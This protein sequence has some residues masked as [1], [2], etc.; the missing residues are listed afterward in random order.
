[1]PSDITTQVTLRSVFTDRIRAKHYARAT[2]KTYWN[3]TVDFVRFNGGRPPRELGAA[4]VEAFLSHLAVERNVSPSTQNQALAALLFLYREVLQLD[5]PWL[6]GITRAKP[7]HFLPTVLSVHETQQLLS[8]ITGTS[9]LI[10]RLLY[11]TGMRVMECLRLRVGDVDMQRNVVTVRQGKGGKDRT[12]CLPET[13]KHALRMQ[14]DLRRHL[15]KLDIE[16]GMVDVELPDA[17]IRKYPRARFEWPWQWIFCTRGYLRIPDGSGVRRHHIE[18]RPI[19]RA[20]RDASRLARINKRVTPHT[21]RHCFAT[22]LLEGGAD[23]RTVQ[24][25]LGHSD[26]STT[27]IYTHVMHRVGLGTISPLDRILTA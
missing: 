1:M 8:H 12:T 24:E 14:F 9:G 10:C 2:E 7:R 26:V 21:M 6:D 22:H 4:E 17:L 20:F 19:Q 25:L 13:L 23:I 11:G 5:L 18:A 16:R 27:Q 3:W 15:H